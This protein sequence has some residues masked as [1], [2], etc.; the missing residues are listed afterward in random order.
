MLSPTICK[1]QTCQQKGEQYGHKMNGHSCG[2]T[3]IG[4]DLI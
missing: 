3:E 4:L 2:I 1:K